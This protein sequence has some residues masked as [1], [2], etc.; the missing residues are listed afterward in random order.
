MVKKLGKNQS[1]SFK[2]NS[3]QLSGSPQIDRSKSRAATQKPAAVNLRYFQKSNECFSKWQPRELKSFSNFILKMAAKTESQVTSM[4]GTCHSHKGATSKKL[5]AGVS[6]DVRM[7]SLDV[8][9]KGRIHGFFSSGTF[10]LVWIDRDGKIL[11]H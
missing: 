2:I 5:P 1:K 4:T 11:G 10:F 3:G 6:K 9:P 8:G 7:Y